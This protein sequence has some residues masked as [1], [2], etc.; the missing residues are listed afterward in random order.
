M[1]RVAQIIQVPYIS[2]QDSTELQQGLLVP[3][4][5]LGAALLRADSGGAARSTG[6][7]TTS[8]SSPTTPAKTVAAADAADAADD[9][10]SSPSPSTPPSAFSPSQDHTSPAPLPAAPTGED[11]LEW[12][13]QL[14]PVACLRK[15]A[16]LAW[17]LGAR[18]SHVRRRRDAGEL[19]S[20]AASELLALLRALFEHSALQ[21]DPAAREFIAALEAEGR[22]GMSAGQVV[23]KGASGEEE[24]ELA[25]GL[26]LS[27]ALAAATSGWAVAV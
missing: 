24:V 17:V 6:A 4:I 26:P 9:F 19:S 20:L 16:Q 27:P 13:Q 12:E 25:T 14:P 15:A 8:L 22:G 2:E 3:I 1:N 23:E 10:A 7:A 21:S 18:L 11:L 5:T